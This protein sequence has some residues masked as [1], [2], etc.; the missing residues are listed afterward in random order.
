MLLLST[1]DEPARNLVDL[2]NSFFIVL[3]FPLKHTN[4]V[5]LVDGL[6]DGLETADLLVLLVKLFLMGSYL[7]GDFIV[8]VEGGSVLV[9]LLTPS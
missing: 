3:N 9:E 8:T 4:V 1:F 6:D 2:L 5:V 7:L